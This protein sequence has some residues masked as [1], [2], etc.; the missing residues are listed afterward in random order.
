VK[1][2]RVYDKS[3]SIVTW[4]FF[5]RFFPNIVIHAQ[6]DARQVGT[7]AE[8]RHGDLSAEDRRTC[9]K[10]IHSGDQNPHERGFNPYADH[11][12]S[13]D[14]EAHV[15]LEKRIAKQKK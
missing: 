3:A 15:A 1:L 10:I 9:N 12:K 4:Y 6:A 7:A 13:Y 11:T 8:L 5:V 14:P 2:K